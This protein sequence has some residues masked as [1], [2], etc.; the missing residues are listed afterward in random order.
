MGY[1]HGS[2]D[3]ELENVS[4]DRIVSVGPDRDGIQSENSVLGLVAFETNAL[5]LGE[6]FELL[7]Q[8]GGFDRGEA[9]LAGKRLL[10]I[11]WNALKR[12]GPAHVSVSD[13][14]WHI[15]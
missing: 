11:G 7:P 9:S 15:G 1:G 12:L 4:G 6:P 10:R 5:V 13:G 8:F 3:S 14:R 2:D